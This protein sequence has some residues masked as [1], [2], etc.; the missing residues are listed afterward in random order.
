MCRKPQKV[1]KP[2]GGVAVE[3]AA[4][5]WRGAPLQVPDTEGFWSL[6]LL[7]LLGLDAIGDG[8]LKPCEYCGY[9]AITTVRHHPNCAGIDSKMS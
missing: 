9:V 1:G 4:V 5:R 8:S 2:A 3:G 6:A 7:V